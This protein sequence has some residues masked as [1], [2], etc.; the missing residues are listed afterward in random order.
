MPNRRHI[1]CK[2]NPTAAR[3]GPIPARR[4]DGSE[5]NFAEVKIYG[6]QP[7]REVAS[8]RLR[9]RFDAD[10]QSVVT[11]SSLRWPMA[12]LNIL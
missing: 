2:V 8:I 10:I 6:W 11:E 7:P 4:G 12:S 9:S 1:T 5:R 3:I